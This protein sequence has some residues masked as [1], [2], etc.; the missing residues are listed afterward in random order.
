MK[1]YQNYLL[2]LVLPLVACSTNKLA[3]VD[4][5]DDNVYVSNAK[6]REAQP[7]VRQVEDKTYKTEEEVYGDANATEAYRGTGNYYDDDFS[8]SSY[9]YRFRNY[10][11]WRNY[12]DPWYDYRFDPYYYNNYHYDNL[13][14]RN[15]WSINIYSG[16]SVGWYY[17]Y[18]YY[19]YNP[20]LYNPYYRYGNNWGIYSYYN[21]IPYPGYYGGHYNYP[22]YTTPGTYRPRPYRNGDNVN[23]GNG[24]RSGN[25]GNGTNRPAP[26][27]SNGA[28]P[29]RVQE[30]SNPPRRESAQNNDTDQSR[31]S[32]AERYTPPPAPATTSSPRSSDTNQN[33]KPRPART[34]GGR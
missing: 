24:T 11:P 1:N 7:Y 17:P 29:A 23:W 13:Y 9:I 20:W 8:Y 6:A 22:S 34:G 14:F 27:A 10:S 25:Y 30:N 21:V 3:Q 18:N 16:P 26:R 31:P 2:L 12:F 4:P 28:R 19:S 15:S 32:R 33:A 5:N